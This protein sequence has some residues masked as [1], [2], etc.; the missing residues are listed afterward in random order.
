MGAAGDVNVSAGSLFM[1]GEQANTVRYNY[2]ASNTFASGNGGKVDVAVAGQLTLDN[3]SAIGANTF[4]T[5]AAGDVTVSANSLSIDGG[6]AEFAYISSASTSAIDGLVGSGN[7]GTVHVTVAGSL[8]LKNGGYITTSATDAQGSAGDV[9]VVASTLTLDGGTR[10][11]SRTAISSA[12]DTLGNAG[13]VTIAVGGEMQVLNG[14]TISVSTLGKGNAGDL[15]ISAGNLVMDGGVANKEGFNYIASDTFAAGN[16][17]KVGVTVTGL[18]TLDNGASIAANTYGSGT[19]GDVTVS[20]KDVIVDGGAAR[21]ASISSLSGA[22]PGGLVG[23]GDAGAVSVT[24]K[25]SVTLQNGGFISTSASGAKGAAGNVT[26]S[27]GSLTLDGGVDGADITRIFSVTGTP[28]NAGNVSITVTGEMQVLNGA[29]IS[30]STS[31]KGNAGD[32]TVSADSLFMD[33]GVANTEGFDY[34]ASET[35]GAGNGGTVNVTVTGP[36]SVLNGASIEA[37][38]YG[39]GT[40]GDVTV[41]AKDVI[42]DGGAARAASISSLSGASPSGLVGSG[43]AGSSRRGGDGERQCDPPEWRLHQHVSVGR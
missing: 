4:G 7:A 37:N 40:A 18:L 28:E 38:T 27:A 21:A 19:A 41:S 1:D 25:D 8:T 12:T 9:S 26:I 5:G 20:A 32:V 22:G 13:N 17:G 30:V 3:G 6:S 35:K 39:S 36:V 31:S 33:G 43:D 29:T 11:L 42:V 34:I 16:G 14:G 2:I 24:A 10:G 15:T 23:S